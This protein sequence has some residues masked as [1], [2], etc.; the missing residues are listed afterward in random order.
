MNLILGV[1]GTF[2]LQTRKRIPEMGIRRA[3]GAARGSL[4]RMLLAENLLLATAGC[5]IGFLLYWQYA[6]HNGLAFGDE[7]NLEQNVVDNWIGSFGEH[8]MVVSL[9]VYGLIA[10]CV[11]VGT[12]IPAVAVSRVQIVDAIRSRE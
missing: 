4:V 6:I 11:I 9:I 7:V 5:L 2:W 12:L 8:F 1:I 10:V 3:F